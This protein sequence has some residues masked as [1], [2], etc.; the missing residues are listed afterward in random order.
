[1]LVLRRHKKNLGVTGALGVFA[2]ALSHASCMPKCKECSTAPPV[3][4]TP[5]A[6]SATS[7]AAR[8]I[9]TP[10]GVVPD[11]VWSDEERAK[12]VA[13]K[14]L[15]QTD[16]ASYHVVRLLRAEKPH[17]HDRSDLSVFVLSGAV[18]MHFADRVVP[19]GPGD[20][21]A[22]PQGAA[23]WAENV[24]PE[25]SFAYVVFTPAFD[26]KDRRFVDDAK[27]SEERPH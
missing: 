16:A 27:R 3:A 20:V 11:F 15:R 10:D 19:V 2:I 7:L 12:D 18:N 9:V 14:T 24:S 17:V 4:A 8:K 5:V 23:H 6:S 26:G 25:P 22:V 13:L 1:M 21:V